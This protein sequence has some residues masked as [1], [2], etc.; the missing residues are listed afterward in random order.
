MNTLLSKLHKPRLTKKEIATWRENLDSMSI[1]K[2][3]ALAVEFTVNRRTIDDYNELTVAM[4]TTRANDAWEWYWLTNHYLMREPTKKEFW[5]DETQESLE[6]KRARARRKV[7]RYFLRKKAGPR[8][9]LSEE[10]I[11]SWRKNINTMPVEKL[12]A[13]GFELMMN[14]GTADEF[15]HLLVHIGTLRGKDS[16]KWTELLNSYILM[17]EEERVYWWGETA[18]SVKQK[19][20][21]ALQ[22]IDLYHEVGKWIS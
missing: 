8:P 20:D 4:E 13:L 1:E 7:E 22:K 21:G 5:E 11:A 6:E 15:M 14:R 2:L 12:A 10:E 18:E 17:E 16:E 19:L 9:A 3:A